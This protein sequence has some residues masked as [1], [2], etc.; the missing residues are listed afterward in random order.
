MI[1][2]KSRLFGV[3]IKNSVLFKMFIT[4][5][6]FLEMFLYHVSDVFRIKDENNN[7][8][9]T[10]NV[11]IALVSPAGRLNGSVMSLVMRG[12]LSQYK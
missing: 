10:H 2:C 4:I 8:A 1:F 9:L 12:K 3:S 7:V 6:C 5:T 11:I